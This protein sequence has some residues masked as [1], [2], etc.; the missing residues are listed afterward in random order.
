MIQLENLEG[1]TLSIGIRS[2][3]PIKYDSVQVKNRLLDGSYHVQTIGSPQKY[4]EFEILSNHKQVDILNFAETIGEKLKL[5]V[6]DKFYIGYIDEEMDWKRMTMR[7]KNP[8]DR[9][10]VSNLKFIVIGEGDT[11]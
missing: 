11:K 6:D 1:E 5:I 3:S 2:L 9:W 7:Y 10:Y 4:F 8:V